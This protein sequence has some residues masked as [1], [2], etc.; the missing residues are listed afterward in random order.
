MN[1]HY[2]LAKGATTDRKEIIC[3]TNEQWGEAQRL[4]YV[5]QLEKAA[6]ALAKGD[7]AVKD[8]SALHPRLRVV[9][10]LRWRKRVRASAQ[11]DPNV[12]APQRLPIVAVVER[13][14]DAFLRSRE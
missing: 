3:H 1:E 14:E 13:N 10:K 2:V 4:T 11:H 6:I 9:A 7:G 12:A 5:R 8:L